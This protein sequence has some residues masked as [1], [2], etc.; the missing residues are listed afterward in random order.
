MLVIGGREGG[1]SPE[2]ADRPTAATGEEKSTPGDQ[3]LVAWGRGV[4]QKHLH[5]TD[6]NHPRRRLL[7]ARSARF[8]GDNLSQYPQEYEDPGGGS[9]EATDPAGE[10]QERGERAQGVDVS[11]RRRI[12]GRRVPPLRRS[13]DRPLERRR[14]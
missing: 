7:G 11:S 4:G 8:S 2:Q 14:H 6:E 1:H 12:D 5:K 13:A 9:S 3:D 10:P